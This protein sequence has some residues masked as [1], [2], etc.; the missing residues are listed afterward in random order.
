MP[1]TTGKT[2]PT[3]EAGQG[4]NTIHHLLKD[5]A[6]DV[7]AVSKRRGFPALAE[8][9]L[10]TRRVIKTPGVRPNKGTRLAFL[11]ARQRWLKPSARLRNPNQCPTD[12]WFCAAIWAI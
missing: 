2:P 3:P 11:P 1:V 10:C 7:A 5:S 6:D 8:R 9:Q 4:P 12:A